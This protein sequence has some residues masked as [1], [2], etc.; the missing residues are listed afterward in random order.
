AEFA[1]NTA[2]VSG[3]HSYS[4]SELFA[5][6]R[7]IRDAIIS[8]GHG[9]AERIGIV[10]GDSVQ[11]TAS[12]LSIWSIGAAFVPVNVHF[13]AYRNAAIIKEAGLDLILTSRPG[14]DWPKYLPEA[15]G[16]FDLIHTGE[17]AP[18][19]KSLPLPQPDPADVAYLFFT[20]G[21]TGTPKGVPIS[22]ANLSSFMHAFLSDPDYRFG[23]RDRFL[24]MFELT[25][26]LSMVSTLAP[27]SVGGSCCVVPQQGIAYMNI[28]D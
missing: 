21:S 28:I 27:L 8:S 25:F 3:E 23:P 18:V 1:G 14:M 9:G 24:Q 5:F 16:S 7:G 20:S 6:A 11:T 10:G 22:H 26:D 15:A 19:A 4:Y 13:P 12:L 2:F 17:I